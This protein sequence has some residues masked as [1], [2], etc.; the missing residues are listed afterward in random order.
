[1]AKF[2]YQGRSRSG[3]EQGHIIANSKRDAIFSLTNKG[4]KVI[5]VQEVEQSAFTK[6]IVIGAPVKHE[7]LTI[8]LRQFAT[9]L[10]AGVTI[11]DATAILAEQT[12]SKHLAK[13]LTNIEQELRE[14]N[15]F[16]RSAAK[17]QRIF[18]PMFINM[19]KAG[20]AGGNMEETLERLAVHYEKQNVTRQKIK[21][22]L[23][24]PVVVGI[25]AV[26][27][28]IFL[29]VSIVPTFASMFADFGEELPAIT[30]SV[31]K[32]S[33]V[34]QKFWYLVILFFIAIF[35][36]FSV[37]KSNK[38][39]KYYLDYALLRMPV[40]GKLL[41]K[42]ALARM[43]RTLSSLF[44]SSV[45]ILQ[46]MKIVEEVVENEVI[47]KVI[48]QSR[49]SL[50]RGQSIALPM[51][52]HWAFPPLVTQMITIGEQTGQ[53]D[54][55]LSK[56]AD[57]YEREVETATDQLKSL[58]E[59]LMIVLLAGVIGVIVASIMIPMFEIYNSVG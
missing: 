8:Y 22:A 24:Y 13:T 25:I 31:L 47:G 55:M 9:L 46:A 16:S 18:S 35:I 49:D 32:A 36:L 37:I 10:R 7:H 17:Y 3:K 23:A 28:T 21:S 19:V 52:K 26:I 45:P 56:V 6:D 27:V 30:Q 2:A 5:N 38:K 20:E 51:K 34:M 40:F 11:V 50:E 59:P 54:S 29:L 12:E 58:I 1:M 44:S 43:T 39:T 14:G 57:F 33:E 48:L 53:L 15:P 4:I 41:Q 42:S